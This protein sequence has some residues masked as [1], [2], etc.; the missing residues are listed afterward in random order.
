MSEIRIKFGA[1]LKA[2]REN[3]GIKLEDMAEQLKISQ[4]NLEAIEKGDVANLPS[5]LYT[6]LFTKSYAEALGIDYAR[7]MEAIEDDIGPAKPEP[8]NGKAPKKSESS[9]EII[10]EETEEPVK[11][12]KMYKNLAFL[13]GG[14]LVI[15]L[16]FLGVN[17]F[18][19]S[20]SDTTATGGDAATTEENVKVERAVSEEELANFDWNNSEYVPDE[21]I[22]I[23]FLPKDQSWATVIADGDTAIYRT[24]NAG[25]IY[26][27]EAD[28]RLLVSVGIPS[29]VDIELNG[30]KINL[31]NPDT[32][33]ISRVDINQ[34]NLEQFL[35]NAESNPPTPARPQ[36]TEPDNT[37]AGDES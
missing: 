35:A 7:T 1:L 11:E 2:E 30:K 16:A 22:K 13:F 20:D 8:K 36:K 37:G 6:N 32:R 17:K 31:V 14:L 5:D 4:D 18:F 19:L 21:K 27:V 10:E 34:M 23:R 15:F 3:K 26:E 33:R 9:E 29:V 28:Y 24:L 25:R 12:N